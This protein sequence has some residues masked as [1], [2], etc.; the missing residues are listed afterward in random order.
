MEQRYHLST[1]A[2]KTP[3]TRFTKYLMIRHKI[4]VFWFWFE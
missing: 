2:A 4:I 3:E 1:S